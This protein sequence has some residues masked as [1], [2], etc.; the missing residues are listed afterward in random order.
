[1][2]MA[3]L[4]ASDAGRSDAIEALTEVLEYL[5]GRVDVIDGAD[6][7]FRPNREMKLAVLCSTALSRLGAP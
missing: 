6:G 3:E 1:M 2:K 7:N 4:H 5:E